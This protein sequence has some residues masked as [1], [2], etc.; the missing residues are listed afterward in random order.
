[1][2]DTLTGQ[3]KIKII[4]IRFLS[5]PPLSS[6]FFT[7]SLSSYC[8]CEDYCDDVWMYQMD[9]DSWSEVLKKKEK[10]RINL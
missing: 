7:S 6:S 9:R 1:M 10:R 5:D 2:V 4:I 8:R 3:I